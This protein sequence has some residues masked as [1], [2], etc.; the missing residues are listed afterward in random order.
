MERIDQS[1]L[2]INK[3][4]CD[5]IEALAPIHRGLLS[6][7]I[8]SQLR[9][10]VEHVALKIYA[11]GRDLEITYDNLTKGINHIKMH[12]QYRVLSKFHFFLQIVA[13]HYTLDPENSERLMLKYYEYLLRLKILLHDQYGLDIL[14]NINKFPL[15]TDRCMIEYYEKIVEQLCL[16]SYTRIKSTYKERFYIQKNTL[17]SLIIRSITK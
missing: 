3:A 2:T 17:F 4:I 6:Q 7:N 1:I 9:T 13:S 15:H 16:P 11:A 10:L 5:N 14:E 12:G 8:L